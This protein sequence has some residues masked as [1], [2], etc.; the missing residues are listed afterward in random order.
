MSSSVAIALVIANILPIFFLFFY[1]LKMA[2]D[3]AIDIETGVARGVPISTRYRGILLYSTWAGYV[4]G[5]MGIGLLGVVVNVQIAGQVA[6]EGVKAMANVA[7]VFGGVAAIAVLL[8]GVSE[9]IHYRSVLRQ[10]QKH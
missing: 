6:D 10:A 8:N 5:A 2:N 4:T 1:I 3:V 9:F 7:A